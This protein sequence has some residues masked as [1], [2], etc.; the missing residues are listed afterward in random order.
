M[1]YDRDEVVASITEYYTFL[2]THLH[3]DP[4]E[5]KIP[6]PGGW[7]QI[8]A[9]RFAFLGKSDKVID[10]LRHLP[11]LPADDHKEFYEHSV[12]ADY[13]GKPG[14]SAVKYQDR[15]DFVP[16]NDLTEDGPWDIDEDTVVLGVTQPVSSWPRTKWYVAYH[17]FRMLTRC[18]IV[19]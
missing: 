19:R 12:C 8:T 14:D 17:L 15:D 1:P 7:P 6:P 16:E 4:S 13:V 11:Y 9:S 10:L 18:M 3:F 2:T 5:L